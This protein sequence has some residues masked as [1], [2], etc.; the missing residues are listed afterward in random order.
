MATEQLYKAT[1][2]RITQ[3]TL[4][5]PSGA[6]VFV[7]E[8]MTELNIFEDL[9]SSTM[10]GNII[11]TDTQNLINSLPITGHEYLEVKFEKPGDQLQFSKIFR[12]YKLTD[13]IR[14]NEQTETYVLHFA[15]E[16]L[17][18]SESQLISKSYSGLTISS[19]V[20][21]I[22]QKYLKI[23]R[24]KLPVQAVQTTLGLHQ[25]II[26]SWKPFYTI[27]W[28]AR[29][30]LSTDKSA[31]YVWYEDRNGY[32]FSSIATLATKGPV[33]QLIMSPKQT[34]TER[35]PTFTDLQLSQEGMETYT[36][37]D[38]FDTLRNLFSGM[39]SSELITVDPFRHAIQTVVYNGTKEFD[40]H[41]HLN[42]YPIIPNTMDRL[43]VPISEHYSAHRTVHPVYTKTE[44][45]LKYDQWAH[46]RAMYLAGL[47]STRLQAVAAGSLRMKVGTVITVKLPSANEQTRGAKQLDA[48][49]S[50]RYLVTAL[51]HKINRTS[52]ACIV[53]LCKDSY[54]QVLKSS[55]ESPFIQQIK[56]S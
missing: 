18:L 35:D 51:R 13:R 53:E 8:L 50:G 36:F 1:D 20:L 49:Y 47:H 7:R 31:S 33:Q 4:I 52:H 14:V 23:S 21:D 48:F 10:T 19:M 24:S 5:A 54:S 26:P 38:S 46:P 42:T 27:N 11:L 37:P 39:Y 43:G 25:V 16:E 9:F 6:T 29:M 41:T 30:A 12:V 40:R 44:F 34:G 32:H 22:A 45:P 55:S 3:L 15:S 17:L 56:A 28:L 2:V